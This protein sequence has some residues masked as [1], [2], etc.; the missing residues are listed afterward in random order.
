MN[1]RCAPCVLTCFVASHL[2]QV[3]SV[4]SL[5]FCLIFAYYSSVNITYPDS[6]KIV[7][8]ILGTLS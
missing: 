7:K 3:C 2:F 8:I 4:Y 1:C 6:S 5:S